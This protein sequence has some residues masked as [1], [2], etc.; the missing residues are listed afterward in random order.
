MSGA[1]LSAEDEDIENPKLSLKNFRSISIR[2]SRVKS[3]FIVIKNGAFMNEIERD[4]RMQSNIFFGPF[5]EALSGGDCRSS[6]QSFRWLI[7]KGAA[8]SVAIYK[9]ALHHPLDFGNCPG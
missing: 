4:F 3:A 9:D 8:F 7:A 5:G 6:G 1:D 2:K